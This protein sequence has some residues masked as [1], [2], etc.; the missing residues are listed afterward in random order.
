M[1]GRYANARSRSDLMDTFQVDE[2]HADEEKKPDFNV[3]PTKTPPTVLARIPK[4]ASENALPERE[5]RNLRWGLIP[6][7][8]KTPSK[9]IINARAET[10]HEKPS[11]RRAFASRRLLVPVD[12][13]YEWFPTEQLG[14]TGKP[15]KQPFFIHPA[16]DG[17]LALAGLYGFWKD[18]DKAEDDPDRWLT[19]FTIITTS[20]TDDVGRIHERMPMAVTPENWEAWLDPRLND[21]DQI[22]SLMAPP[23]PGSL[24]IYA[25]STSVNNVKNNGPDL[26]APIP[27][28][29]P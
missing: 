20:A 18:P 8:S 7:W 5:L 24:D 6:T 14:K 3:T 10:V 17:V 12:G 9:G 19:T 13:F 21:L 4:D 25:V 28:E 27:A 16:D 2:E 22:R 1:C 15:L 29:Y 23:A 26:I 11:F